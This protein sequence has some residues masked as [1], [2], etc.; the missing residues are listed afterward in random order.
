MG[1]LELLMVVP[2]TLRQ[3]P[4]GGC[5]SP[6]NVWLEVFDGPCLKSGAPVTT[7]QIHSCRSPQAYPKNDLF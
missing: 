3:H 5:C 1:Y 7:G 4:A 2:L 6:S